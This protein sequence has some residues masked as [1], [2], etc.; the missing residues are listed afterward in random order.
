MSTCA[1]DYS[2]R[3]MAIQGESKL[4]TSGPI[5]QGAGSPPSPNTQ[6][7]TP[8]H[9]P[10]FAETTSCLAYSLPVHWPVASIDI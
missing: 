2:T 10:V 9:K 3:A 4:R 1:P 6:A 7:L 5:D 8:L